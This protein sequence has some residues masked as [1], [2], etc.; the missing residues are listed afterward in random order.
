MTDGGW[1]LLVLAGQLGVIPDQLHARNGDEGMNGPIY[2]R[3]KT[4]RLRQLGVSVARATALG[5]LASSALG[6]G[7]GL[8][9]WVAGG[10][11]SPGLSMATL[12]VGPVLGA[13]AG[14]WR[15][16]GWHA[17]ASAVDATYNLKDRSATALDFLAR[18]EPTAVHAL[19]LDDAAR[20]LEQVEAR[21][22]VPFRLSRSWPVAL[23][24]LAIALALLVMPTAAR[25]VKAAPAPP[26]AIVLEQTERIG[27]DLKQLDELA[28]SERN[29]DL[30][31]LV[32]QLRDKVEEMKQLGVDVREAL[33][34]ISEM[35]AAIASMQAQ[36]NVGLVD[37][38]L[39]SLG[40]AL[41]PAASLEA[42]GKD[43]IEA[44]F[45][46]AAQKLDAVEEPALD[47]KEAKTVREELKKVADKMGKAGLGQLG[48]AAGEMAEGLAG[49]GEGKFKKGSKDLAKLVQG[50]GSR[51]RIKEILDAELAK[52]SECKGECQSDKTAR[53]RMPTKTESPSQSWGAGISG[54]INGPKTERKSNRDLKEITG[55]P[56]DGASEVETTH[57]PEGR[58][59]A[60]R[61]YKEAYQKYR[62][63]SEAVLDS[64]PIPLGHRQTIRRY[65]ELI[66]PQNSGGDSTDAP[67]K[68][69]P[70]P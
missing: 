24:A 5:L 45:D 33:A 31:K 60:D 64:E 25:V 8:W 2:Q 27:D 34:K 41:V 28:R 16:P 61:G 67:A 40:E 65:F 47:R 69:A 66:R 11:V 7:L 56:G 42:A 9:R 49:G 51:R 23:V 17:A 62:K 32:E 1:T 70:T 38:Q 3:L 68:A 19:Q 58:Q 29:K 55:K 4:V 22:V 15:R 18:P 63:M 50:H 36:F 21:A 26:P 57:S 53:I 44:K 6:I 59:T 37:A 46:K 48:E 52:L 14:V 13:L 43:L 20:H 54:N 35:Q 39:H 30:G 10:S 12:V